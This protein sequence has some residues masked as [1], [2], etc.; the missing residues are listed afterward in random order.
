[1]KLFPKMELAVKAMAL[2]CDSDDKSPIA[3]SEVYNETWLLRMALA[4]LHDSTKDFSSDVRNILKD[5]RDAVRIGWISEGGLRPTLKKEG[6]TWT[7][8]ILGNVALKD[9]EEAENDSGNKRGVV[10]DYRKKDVGVIVV[11]AKVG[12]RLA[13]QTS[14]Y[15]GYNQAARNIACLARLIM[16]QKCDKEGL[17]EEKCRFIVICPEPRDKDKFH[18]YLRENWKRAKEILTADNII[19]TINSQQEMTGELGSLFDKDNVDKFKKIVDTIANEDR[20]TVVSWE[21]IL[22]RLRDDDID[23]FYQKVLEVSCHGKR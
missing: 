13:S 15:P 5:L 16:E 12:S 10:I 9:S 20:S 23:K 11:E 1:M 18:H 7:D 4:K 3:P 8:A 14:N 21:D 2:C 19:K 6:T 17:S 22:K